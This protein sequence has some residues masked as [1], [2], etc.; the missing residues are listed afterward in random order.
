[1]LLGVAGYALWST[2]ST[3][4]TAQQAVVA[5]QVSDDYAFAARAVAAQEALERTYLL[6]PSPDVRTRFRATTT[7]LD[8]ALD[9]VGRHGDPADR[10]R[11]VQVK[12]NA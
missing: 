7:D 4:H 2:S 8:A 3:A 5:S 12:A 11:A 10:A 6:Q 1:V 9:R